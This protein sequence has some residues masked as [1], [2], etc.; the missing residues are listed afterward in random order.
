[1]KRT[2][3]VAGITLSL[4]LLPGIVGAQE[5][6]SIFPRFFPEDASRPRTTED[7]EEAKVARQEAIG[8]RREE[9]QAS[10]E[11]RLTEVRSAR[12]RSFSER[13]TARLQA[14]IERLGTLITR[15]ES[16]L[17]KIGEGTDIDTVLIQG[18]LDTA[19]TLLASAQATLNTIEIEVILEAD[20][21]KEAFQDIREAIQG[22]RDD[23]K[24]VHRILVSVIGDIKGL[25]VGAE[26]APSVTSEATPTPTATP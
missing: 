20:N 16:R 8:Q 19:N 3:I 5:T 17:L 22:I 2:L 25:R 13:L 4:L 15:I 26:N 10:R 21:P 14:L 1:M 18:D 23:L 24:Q 6:R 9:R 11:A 7:K 12:I